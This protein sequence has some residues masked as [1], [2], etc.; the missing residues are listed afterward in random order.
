LCA[1]GALDVLCNPQTGFAVAAGAFAATVA[2][3]ASAVGRLCRAQ[4]ERVNVAATAARELADKT[5]DALASS[6]EAVLAGADEIADLKAELS[7]LHLLLDAARSPAIV[8]A[9]G[10]EIWYANR[11]AR[12]LL[13][14]QPNA[15]AQAARGELRS[16][17]AVGGAL[18]LPHSERASAAAAG[19]GS[20]QWW[21]D[22]APLRQLAT[23]LRGTGSLVDDDLLRTDP[24]AALG[25]LIASVGQRT[26][27]G[28][29]Q[30]VAGCDDIDRA[31][32]L[33]AGAID[34]LLTSFVGLEGKVSRQT[35]I[36][37]SLVN[38]S[39][40]AAGTQGDGATFD[41][42]QGFITSVERTIERVIADGAEVSDVAVQMTGTIAAIGQAMAHLV[43]SFSEVERIAEQT[44]LLALNASIEAA[45]AGS[46]GRGFAVVA[47]EVGKLA[48]RS[49]GLSNVVRTMIDG[50]RRDLGGAESG[51]AAIVSKDAAY[52]ATSQKTLKHIF[53]GGR[54]VQNQ[55]TSTLQALSANAQDVSHD[56]RAAVIGLHFHDLTSQLLA[57]TRGRFGVLQ[58]LMEGAQIVPE[59][60][61]IGAVSQGSMA[62]GDVDLF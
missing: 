38:R 37:A 18:F 24:H 30:V 26:V 22:L 21:D 2:Y 54:E 39:Q 17:V 1:A 8:T 46:A 14:A 61:S 3:A 25:Q 19:V 36:A 31:Q 40:G 35:D 13:A 51:M 16:P 33:I 4:D 52:R 20:L 60:R 23:Q 42:I 7:A 28:V 50:I 45:R 48:T 41:S 43:E 55:T 62:S 11:P 47:S 27:A 9:E 56:V 57:H 58:S 53:D 29:E 5:A 49:T 44:N 15:A 59:I 32:T 12:T 6:E 10:G 34:T